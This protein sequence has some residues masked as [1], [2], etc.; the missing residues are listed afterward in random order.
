MKLSREN[1]QPHS[2]NSFARI[3]F[4]LPQFDTHYHYHPEVEITW[5]A[6]SEGQRLVGDALE[7]FEPGDLILI[8]GNVPHQYCNWKSGRARS[9][10]IQFRQEIL[11]PG[12]L[13]L[14][15]FGRVRHLLDLA[16][17]GVGFSDEVRKAALQQMQRVFKAE[18]GPSTIIAL[19]ELLRILSQEESPRQIASV[20][21]AEPVK[22]KKIDRLQRVL[23]YLEQ[24]WQET[25]TLKE[26]A[27]AAALHPQSMSRFFQQH[28]GMSFQD[29][30]IQLRIGRAARLLL[31]TERT[32]V[33]IA[34][35]CGFNNLANFNRHFQ[36]AYK[37]T[38]SAYRKGL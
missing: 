27:Q 9:R 26:A 20:V 32:V 6:E 21:Y 13:D 17:R 19:L 18:E 14:A 4:D 29:Y 11:A 2:G 31:E 25:V 7:A 24:N 30:L 1:I 36:N 22:L 3:E 12:V 15:E 33:D 8:G 34:F 5:I 37:K 38:P 10:V 16:A 23:N 28:L 35:H